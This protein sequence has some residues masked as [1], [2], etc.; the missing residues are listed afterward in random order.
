MIPEQNVAYLQEAVDKDVQT[1]YKKL[2]QRFSTSLFETLDIM[3]EIYK[4]TN[5]KADVD[6]DTLQGIYK[7]LIMNVWYIGDVKRLKELTGIAPSE[8]AF[9]ENPDFERWLK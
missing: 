6:K 1:A 4:I 8:E 5:V 7:K 2:E 3:L 9:K